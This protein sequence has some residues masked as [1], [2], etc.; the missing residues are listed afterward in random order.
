MRSVRK[1]IDIY[2]NKRAEELKRN[3][4][5]NMP[6]SALQMQLFR[7]EAV[8]KAVYKYEVYIRSRDNANKM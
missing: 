6:Y 4:V 1:A 2:F 8:L 5:T 7:E 3:P